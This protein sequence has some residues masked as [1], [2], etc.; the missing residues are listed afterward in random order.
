MGASLAKKPTAKS[1]AHEE[2]MRLDRAL[3]RPNCFGARMKPFYS[4]ANIPVHSTLLMSTPEEARG[5]PRGNLR[6]AF[7]PACAFVGNM[8]YDSSVQDYNPNSEESQAFSA[9][10][11]KFA[12]A[13]ASRWV[14]RYG[15][16]NK[17]VLE[18]GCGKA[19][20]LM[21]LCEAG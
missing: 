2:P 10:F 5:Y 19:D 7:C 18:I 3:R 17:T 1:A 15:I 14:E 13:L 8:L 12:Q 6:L 11:N 16:R 21:L 20:F 4:A 9:T